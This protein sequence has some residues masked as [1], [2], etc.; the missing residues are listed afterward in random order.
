LPNATVVALADSSGAY[1][2]VPG[3]NALIAAQWGVLEGLPAWPEL[4][5]LT[6]EQVSVPGLF[7]LAGKHDPAIRFA[8][9]DF[10]ADGTQAFFGSLAGFDAS[11]LVQLIDQNEQEIQAAGVDVVSYVAPGDEHTSIGRPEFYTETVEGV[12]LDDWVTDLVAGTPVGD[13]HCVQCGGP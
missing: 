5:G 6:P 12:A 11:N 1:P 8:R 10:A 2:D 4:A 7:V 3:V 13:V 9:H